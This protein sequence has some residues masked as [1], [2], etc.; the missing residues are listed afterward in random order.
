MTHARATLKRCRQELA[1]LGCG[2]MTGPA[3]PVSDGADEAVEKDGR[4]EEDV[5]GMSDLGGFVDWSGRRLDAVPEW[6]RRTLVSLLEDFGVAGEE[7]LVF[8]WSVEADGEELLWVGS[9]EELGY[10]ACGLHADAEEAYRL[11]LIADQ[12][13]DILVE[14]SAA[15]AGAIP[16]CRPGHAHPATPAV[17]DGKAIW[18]CGLDGG[19]LAPLGELASRRHA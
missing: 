10:A 12:L 6:F 18:I 13:Q 4:Q 1:L 17:V 3:G 2:G 8:G 9:R 14:T 11:V 15:W 19:V 5:R 16:P 7:S